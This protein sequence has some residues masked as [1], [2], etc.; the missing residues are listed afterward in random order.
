MNKP[1]GFTLIELMITLAIA[2]IVVTFGIPSFRSMMRDNRIAAHTNEFIGALN[3]ARSEAIK[4]G[5]RVILEPN[6]AG[7][8]GKGWRIA[9]DTNDN[10]KVDN[11]EVVLR[12][13]DSLPNN[14]GLIP[15]S[16]LNNYISFAPDGTTRFAGSQAFQAGTLVLS[17]CD[18]VGRQSS[19][20]INSV[21][22]AQVSRRA[23]SAVACTK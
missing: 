2:A 4:R 3:L 19:I 1:R 5:E 18:D 14:A 11:G 7:N 9:V 13:F 10:G 23:A 15:N 16:P 12:Q 8:W 17:L 20:V 22:R 21:G 6:T